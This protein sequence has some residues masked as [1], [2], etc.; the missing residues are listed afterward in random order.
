MPRLIHL[1]VPNRF[2][3]LTYDSFCAIA[4][5]W[6][7]ANPVMVKKLNRCTGTLWALP[8]VAAGNGKLLHGFFRPAVQ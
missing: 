8:A 5:L 3:K 1:S 6:R 7:S 2:L 4:V